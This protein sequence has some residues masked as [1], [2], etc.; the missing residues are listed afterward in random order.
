MSNTRRAEPGGPLRQERWASSEEFERG[1]RGNLVARRCSVMDNPDDRQ[2]VYYLQSRSLGEG[3]IDKVAADLL[4][5]FA[6]RFGTRAMQQFGMKPGQVYSA[7]QVKAIRREIES[8][9]N[10]ESQWPLRW[11]R[12]RYGTYESWDG[13]TR[14]EDTAPES[15]PAEVFIEHCQ[16]AARGLAGHLEEFCLNPEIKAQAGWPWYFPDLFESLREY[17]AAFIE[18]ERAAFVTETGRQVDEEVDYARK[19]KCLV[20]IE[21]REG[22]GKSF[23][24][25]AACEARPGQARYSKVPP[26]NDDIGFFQALAKSV[27][28]ACGT[29]WKTVQLRK[30]LEDTLKSGDL[31]LVLDN[32]QYLW[33]VSDCRHAMPNRINWLMKALVEEGVPVV[34]IASPQFTL[35]QKVV[36]NRT[37][38]TS[39]EFI[40]GIGRYVRLP[41][42]VGEEDLAKVAKL[43]LPEG[44]GKSIEILVRYAQSTASYFAGIERAVRR[45][46]Y[47]AEK[48]GRVKV[49]RRDIKRAVQADVIPSDNALASALA[50]PAKGTGK[51]AAVPLQGSF[52]EPAR[53]SDHADSGAATR[54]DFAGLESAED[55]GRNRLSSSRIGRE[56][57]PA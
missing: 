54:L 26:G 7:S 42:S 9:L 34:L 41:E 48:A 36:E 32:A 53:Q 37:H 13:G 51:R 47:V 24:G 15:Y 23:S 29:S 44:D 2:L 21:G 19:A 14:D 8:D 10:P 18:K 30:R 3:G 40:A 55:A 4:A 25:K 38:W 1:L 49:E 57:V 52:M 28:N 33:P 45:A 35:T 22:I 6:D 31:T 27:G 50:D 16:N 20:L 56:I 46:R 11:E 12:D 5:A 43:K 39:G 17:Q